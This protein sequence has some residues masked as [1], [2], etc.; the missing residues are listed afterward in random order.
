MPRLGLAEDGQ[1][2]H[3]ATLFPEGGAKAIQA[4]L[5]LMRSGVVD[6]VIWNRESWVGDSIGSVTGHEG[7]KLDLMDPVAMP[8]TGG[9]NLIYTEGVL[10]AMLNQLNESVRL[11][12]IK[13][14]SGTQPIEELVKEAS[15]VPRQICVLAQRIRFTADVSRCIREDR[16]LNI[17]SRA[18]KE[19]K[20]KLGERLL[21]KEL[22]ECER[23]ASM[24]VAQVITNRLSYWLPSP[25]R[26]RLRLPEPLGK[27]RYDSF[28]MI[29]KMSS[30]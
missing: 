27:S 13:M 12:S 29:K 6:C 10:E 24:A 26:K 9:C 3:L 2:E 30:R 17:I 20:K 28:M 1:L 4:L 21:D 23:S 19:T 16:Q 15:G 11:A 8:P 22:P 14:A 7:D 18:H 25:S 5:N